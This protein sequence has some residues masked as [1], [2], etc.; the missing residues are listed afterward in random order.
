MDSTYKINV[1][2]MSLFEIVGVTSTEKT[3]YIGFAFLT[4]KKEDNFTWVLQ[5]LVDLLK[6]TYNMSK[7]IVIDRDTTL[8]ND[9]TTVFTKTI[10]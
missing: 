2:K 10:N 3:Y 7:V 6:F 8:M 1:C 5:M 9:V 4:S